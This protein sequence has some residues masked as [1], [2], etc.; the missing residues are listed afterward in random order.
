MSPKEG[1]AGIVGVRE[2]KTR[3][4]RYLREVRPRFVPSA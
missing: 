1:K 2:L 3:L 4:G